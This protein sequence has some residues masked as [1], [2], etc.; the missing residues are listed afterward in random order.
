MSSDNPISIKLIDHVV[1]RVES[2]DRM[3]AFYCN[4]LSCQLEKGPGDN[5]LAQLRAGDSLIDLVDVASA[6]G[7][8]GGG[9][10]H[11]ENGNMDHVCLQ[12]EPWQ[13]DKLTAHLSK[14]KVEHGEIAARYGALGYGPSLYLKDPEGNTVELKGSPET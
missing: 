13:E 12:I 1:I 4:V 10:P 3:I 2:L 6:L 11:R 5:G 7:R 9:Q 14:H 8:S